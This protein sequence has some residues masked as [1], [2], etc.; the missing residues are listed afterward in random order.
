MPAPRTF[1]MNSRTCL[2]PLARSAEDLALIY[3]IIAGP[4][5]MDTDL[6]PVPVEAMPKLDLKSLRIAFAPALPGLPVAA[7]IRA[8]A[9]NLARQLQAAGTTVEEA[10]L[11]RLDLHGRPPAGI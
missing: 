8:A 6:A 10:R 4:D 11:P 5:G 1:S 2:G 7:G 3:R 9:E